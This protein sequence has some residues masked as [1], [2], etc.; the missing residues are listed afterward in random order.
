MST[1]APPTLMREVLAL[2]GGLLL[3]GAATGLLDELRA[4]QVFARSSSAAAS[5]SA[6]AWSQ[7]PAAT[8]PA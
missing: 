8:S 1:A 2:L 7:R 6:W 3:E 5:G 4:E